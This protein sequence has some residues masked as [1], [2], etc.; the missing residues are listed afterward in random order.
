MATA[1]PGL[2]G[3]LDFWISG[4]GADL[5]TRHL[6]PEAVGVA[7]ALLGWSLVLLVSRNLF[8]RSAD[9]VDR[10][11]FDRTAARLAYAMS[12]ASS[13]IQ[14]SLPQDPV[15]GAE[16]LSRATAELLQEQRTTVQTLQQLESATQRLEA[17]AAEAGLSNVVDPL[18]QH[19]RATVRHLELEP[20]DVLALTTD[21]VGNLIEDVPEFAE[22]V[23]GRW[24]KRPPSPSE[25]LYFVDAAVK[26]YDDDRT[27][28]LVGFGDDA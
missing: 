12:R 3:F 22:A 25:L 19:V 20:G 14:A 13:A 9:R 7:V 16:V 18:P 26:T 1:S 21:G 8:S 5:P 6:L 27:L 23:G 28:L 11:E 2:S 4:V 10:E 17:S 15:A 24:A